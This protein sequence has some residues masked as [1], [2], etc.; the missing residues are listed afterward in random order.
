MAEARGHI[1]FIPHGGGPLPLLDD[2]AHQ[3]LVQ[4]LQQF[5]K[6]MP[7]PEAIIVISAHWAKRC[8]PC[9]RIIFCYSVPAFHFTICALSSIP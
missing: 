8:V 5:A 9:L 2:P 7:T 1:L 4:F 6:Q 3:Q